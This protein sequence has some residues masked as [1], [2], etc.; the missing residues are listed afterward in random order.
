D[1]SRHGP[2]GGF[3]PL[4]PTLEVLRHDLV[5]R[6][7]LGTATLVAACRRGAGMRP[8]AGPRGKRGGGS[9]HG[10]TGGWTG[11]VIVRTLFV[12]YS[13]PPV[14]PPSRSDSGSGR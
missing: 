6:G 10:Q 12:R 2:L 4:E 9:D 13:P 3:S 1:V 8:E 11:R 5:K 14:G 7:L